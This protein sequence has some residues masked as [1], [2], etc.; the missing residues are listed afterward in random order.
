MR[1]MD[2]TSWRRRHHH[3]VVVVGIAHLLLLLLLL[4]A[5]AGMNT[6][7]DALSHSYYGI[8]RIASAEEWRD[9]AAFRRWGIRCDR[10][11][12]VDIGTRDGREGVM[13]TDLLLASIRNELAGE[14]IPGDTTRYEA[15]GGATVQF[16]A[17]LDGV[18]VATEHAHTGSCCFLSRIVGVIEAE[19]L[20][21]TRGRTFALP[22]RWHIGNLRTHR[23]HR[24]RGIGGDLVDAVVRHALSS[25]CCPDD[26]NTTEMVEAV[27]LKVERDQNPAAV[28]L[29]EKKGFEFDESVYPGFMIK[30]MR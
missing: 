12:Y 29:Y 5:I 14:R 28:K 23:E 26:G 13:T 25:G 3:P 19:P 11:Q 21:P 2:T 8:H 27:T 15:F 24:R 7:T 20:P 10:S 4:L 22:N 1:Q 16:A 30:L 17:V 9:V 18:G 6:G